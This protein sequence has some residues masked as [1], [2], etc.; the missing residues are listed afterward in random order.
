MALTAS[1]I[2]EPAEL[3]FLQAGAFSRKLNAERF[4]RMNGADS[5]EYFV[6]QK[7]LGCGRQYWVRSKN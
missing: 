5:T 6:V 4:V 7:N 1:E 3:F 2:E